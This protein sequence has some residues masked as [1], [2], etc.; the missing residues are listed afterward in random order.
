MR[1]GKQI[2]EKHIK[3]EKGSDL[4][5]LPPRLTLRNAEP[6]GRTPNGPKRSPVAVRGHRRTPAEARC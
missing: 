4:R 3:K 2:K 6:W 1:K 5:R